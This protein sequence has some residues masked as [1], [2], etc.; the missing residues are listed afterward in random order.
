MHICWCYTGIWLSFSDS[1]HSESD[2]KNAKTIADNTEDDDNDDDD[3]D[4]Q[5]DDEED[6]NED[7]IKEFENGETGYLCFVSCEYNVSV[8]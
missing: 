1:S 7:Y 4:L 5:V 2:M 8:I 6:E 3:D